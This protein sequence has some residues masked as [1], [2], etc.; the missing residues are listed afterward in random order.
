M[1]RTL[2][3]DASVFLS[4]LF[5]KEINNG[6]S[7]KFLQKV[8]DLGF[9]VSVPLLTPMEVL[10]SYYRITKD[11]KR[12]DGILEQFVEWN[13]RKR[14][15]FVPIEAAFFSRFTAHH[16]LFDLKTSDTIIAVNAYHEKT[17]LITW[18]KKLIKECKNKIRVLTPKQ[19][20]TQRN[21]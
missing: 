11:L 4:A 9:F 15:R 10:Q 14:I 2:S 18:D 3:I 5:E 8:K 16:R 7:R 20:L 12:S 13:L 6:Y 19:F 17:T 21:A 1:N